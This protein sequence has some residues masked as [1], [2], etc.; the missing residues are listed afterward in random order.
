MNKIFQFLSKRRQQADQEEDQLDAGMAI[1]Q[2]AGK[3]LV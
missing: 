3:A 1:K 2:D